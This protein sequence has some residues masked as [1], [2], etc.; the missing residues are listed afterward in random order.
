[1]LW[2]GASDIDKQNSAPYYSSELCAGN[3]DALPSTPAFEPIS[4]LPNPQQP[5]SG[6]LEGCEVRLS[7]CGGQYTKTHGCDTSITSHS[8]SCGIQ[9]E[10]QLRNYKCNTL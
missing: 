1:M 3:P 2:H 5:Y 9:L 8:L 6:M 10:I 7:K 4:L